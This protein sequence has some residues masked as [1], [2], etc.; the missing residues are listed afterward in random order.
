M[1][2]LTERKNSILPKDLEKKLQARLEQRLEE[3]INYN[4]QEIEDVSGYK[5]RLI[6]QG[7]LLEEKQLED[8]RALSSL[9]RIRLK[10]P[11]EI[12]S[13]RPLVGKL[14]VAVKK[15]SWPLISFHIKDTI[16]AME[17]FSSRM[18][19]SHAKALSR[20]K[21]LENSKLN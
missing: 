20:V 15:A 6:T 21:E 9:S 12:S 19:A 16:E 11:S 14:I 4:R 8:L 10:R 5:H 13:H 18:V 2:L 3:S 17:E 7:T 1:S